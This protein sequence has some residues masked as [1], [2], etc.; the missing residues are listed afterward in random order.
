M[1]SLFYILFAVSIISCQPDPIDINIPQSEEQVVVSNQILPPSVVAVVL[2][3]SFSALESGDPGTTENP[4]T[5]LINQ[6]L[7]PDAAVGIAWDGQS[8]ALTQVQ[9]G[10]YIG[11][12]IEQKIGTTYELT[13]VDPASNNTL[14]STTTLLPLVNLTSAT[15]TKK[16]R[17]ETEG[18]ELNISLNDPIGINYYLVGVYS[19]LTDEA[20]DF[21]DFTT[22]E[23]VQ[24]QFF[25][26][27]DEGIDGQE[28]NKTFFAES[29][30]R[31]TA[32][33][34]LS[35]IPKDYYDYLESME[36]ATNSIP[37]LSEPVT[38]RTNIEGGFG[39]FAMHYPSIRLVEIRR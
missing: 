1:K 18:L 13:I 37:F 6:L 11:A 9:P 36:R 31:D 8:E 10:I 15:A 32:V 16:E 33:V 22:L 14:T 4:N 26:F 19:E 38:P 23:F 30:P 35:N 3:K 7:V 21:N 20:E 12:N 27:T 34:S 2:T 28:I 17:F 25:V 29:W 39:F 5:E 24:S